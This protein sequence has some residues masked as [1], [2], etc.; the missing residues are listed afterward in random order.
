MS[1]TINL[2]SLTLGQIRELAHLLGLQPSTSPAAPASAPASA[3][4]AYPVGECVFV[5]LV[6]YHYTGRLV[7]VTAGELVLED[8]AWVADSGRFGVALESGNLV[9][10]EP[11]PAGRVVLGRGAVVDVSLWR[12]PLPR[13]H[14]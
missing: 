8:A 12:H 7:E 1:T 10:W 14:Q 4:H 2:D 13:S 6:T 5:R 3:P 11:Y 9:E